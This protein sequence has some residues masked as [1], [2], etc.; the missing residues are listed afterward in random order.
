MGKK[1]HHSLADTKPKADPFVKDKHSVQLIKTL[2][3][4]RKYH[5]RAANEKEY[6]TLADLSTE[7]LERTQLAFS[8]PIDTPEQTLL[9]KLIGQEVTFSPHTNNI[10]VT[11]K[12]DKLDAEKLNVILNTF[13]KPKGPP[14][15]PP[16]TEGD[17]H[18]TPKGQKTMKASEMTTDHM[19][20]SL[21]L[22]YNACIPTEFKVPCK[23]KLDRVSVENGDYKHAIRVFFKL[24]AKRDDLKDEHAEQLIYMARHVRK[25]L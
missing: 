24:L 9:D 4:F 1:V 18:W 21:R 7:D 13:F 12:S 11:P 16:D 23:N 3:A 14:A 2:G 5:G 22:C 8:Q 25:Y 10:L 6:L 17:M 20:Y 19:F 15:P